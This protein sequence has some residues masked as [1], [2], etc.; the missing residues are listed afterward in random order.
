MTQ[1]LKANFENLHGYLRFLLLFGA[2]LSQAEHCLEDW[3]SFVFI[4]I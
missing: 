3:N 2:A 1:V 4:T